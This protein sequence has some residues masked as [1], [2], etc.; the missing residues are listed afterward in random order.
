MIPETVKKIARERKAMDSD[1][2][3][4]CTS[5]HLEQLEGWPFG[6]ALQNKI[7]GAREEVSFYVVLVV[8]IL[9]VASFIISEI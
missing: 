9:L 3:S 8:K 2:T 7:S 5:R 6:T 4:N 1:D